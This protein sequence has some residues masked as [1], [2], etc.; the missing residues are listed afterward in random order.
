VPHR[1]PALHPEPRRP[2][3]RPSKLLRSLAAALTAIL[4]GC[5]AGPPAGDV[6]GSTRIAP[7][8]DRIDAVVG[9]TLVIPVQL[10]GAVNPV[11]PIAARLDDGRPVVASLYW[12][13]MSPEPGDMEEPASVDAGSG[14]LPHSGRWAA[15]PAAAGSRPSASG[16][17]VVAVDIPPNS[18]GQGLWL[19]GR[20]TILNWL[21]DPAYVQ[22]RGE[23]VPWRPPLGEDQPAPY[24]IRLAEP[25]LHSPVRRWRYK[26]L[27]NGLAPEGGETL[28]R[29]RPQPVAP[30]LP[31]FE[32]PIL[33]ALARQNESRWQVAL[34]MLWLA[35]AD[36]AERVK[37]RLVAAVDFGR[38]VVTPAW[39]TDQLAIDTLLRDLLNPRLGP[40]QHVERAAAWLDSLPPAAAWVVD[41]A[42]L[43]DAMTGRSMATAGVAN[44][45]ERDTLSWAV[46]GEGAP[47]P[48][49]VPLPPLESRQLVVAQ[50]VP[51]EGAS[52]RPDKGIA[53]SSSLPV[54]IHAGRW[55]VSRSVAM[56]PIP[57]TPPGLRIE[58]LLGDWTM[59]AW[60]AGMPASQMLP[61]ARWVTAGLVYQQAAATTTATTADGAAPTA[62][63]TWWIYVE[64]REPDPPADPD[65]Q[66]AP[67]NDEV[68]RVWLGAFGSPAAV[69]R[70]TRSGMVVDERAADQG[71]GGSLSGASVSRQNGRW[72]AQVP[73]PA[74]A[75][76]PG[77]TLRIGVERTDSRGRRSAWP[78]PMLPWQTEPGR[79]AINTAVWGS[80]GG[81]RPASATR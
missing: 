11:K 78:R 41:D 3:A 44:L 50:A 64:C 57:V 81:V 4:G 79:A 69:L 35:D 34:A 56:D 37:R 63:P 48:D 21:P 66:A 36:L 9:R 49:L 55:S 27:M 25:E 12:I 22:G 16:S 74:M 65:Q 20:R 13:S 51:A 26:L 71:L 14:W 60:L 18:I 72:V 10:Q 40:A 32:D 19:G 77:G 6:R 2:A 52:P 45:T 54:S 5:A 59:A 30:P 58:P 29:P 75:I 68:V 42:G 47:T 23:Q 7:I 24:L 61:Q 39:P 43:R 33:E 76:E 17:W 46:A 38:G 67:A 1:T 62:A 73:I 28:T 80:V 70:I 15:T 8:E 53:A 31:A